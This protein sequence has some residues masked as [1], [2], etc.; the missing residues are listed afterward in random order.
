[1]PV[2]IPLSSHGHDRGDEGGKD[3]GCTPG[4]WADVFVVLVLAFALLEVGVVDDVGVV[5]GP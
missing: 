5:T 1:M 3:E 2:A 4:H